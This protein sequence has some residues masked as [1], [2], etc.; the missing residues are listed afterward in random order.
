MLIKFSLELLEVG[1]IE[2]SK[3]LKATGLCPS[4]GM[5]KFVISEGSV[6]V[7]GVVEYRKGRKIAR[8]QKV[9]Y[10]KSI[11]EVV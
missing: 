11:I 4:G 9:E 6:R 1:Y 5:A 3:L 7:D 2:L 10:Q 8:G